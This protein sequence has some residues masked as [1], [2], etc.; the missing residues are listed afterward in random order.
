M[1]TYPIGGPTGPVVPASLKTGLVS[2]WTLDEPSAGS[3][4]VDRADS[5]GSNTAVDSFTTV[6]SSTEA[7]QG[8]SLGAGP[9]D[10][11]RIATP[12]GM[13]P[14]ASSFSASVWVRAAAYAG[15]MTPF[16]VA[17]NGGS[18]SWWFQYINATDRLS[19][20]VLSSG[21]KIATDTNIGSPSINTWYHL[22][23]EFDTD[24]N[25][26]GISINNG[27]MDT[28]AVTGT[29]YASGGPA[30]IGYL[31]GVGRY[32]NGQIDEAAYWSRILTTDERTSVF[33]DGDG[34]TYTDIP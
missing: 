30:A 33:Q 3:A 29:I 32:W 20:Q 28:T 16:G 2:W 1:F 23:G 11:I 5:H 10:Y 13:D 26:I 14:G 15:D 4:Q 27:A 18:L 25:T 8:L 6:P 31:N 7:K 22:Y 17:A 34:I 24:A 19:M 21:F 9:T 12:H